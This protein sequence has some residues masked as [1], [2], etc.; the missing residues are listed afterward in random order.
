MSSCESFLLMMKQVSGCKLIG[1]RSYGSSGN[2]QPVV[3]ANGVIAQLPCWQDLRPDGSCFEGE[4]IAPDVDIPGEAK[5]FAA[6]DPVLEAALK[7]LRPPP[8][9]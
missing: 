6:R 8:Q 9:K 1:R 7:Q 2:P 5:D 3:L 4:G